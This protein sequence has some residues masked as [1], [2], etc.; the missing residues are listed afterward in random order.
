MRPWGFFWIRKW[1]NYSF[2]FK[3]FV[4]VKIKMI[5]SGRKLCS[6]LIFAV[7]EQMAECQLVS[8][9]GWKNE[10]HSVIFLIHSSFSKLIRKFY[11]PACA[12]Y[13]NL[14]KS[15]S[16]SSEIILSFFPF[17]LGA[18]ILAC[19]YLHLCQISVATVSYLTGQ[20]TLYAVI[21]F[22]WRAR[23]LSGFSCVLSWGFLVLRVSAYPC[24]A[25]M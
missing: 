9:L 2:P 6:M 14:R 20:M 19:K 12:L 17:S 13:F 10:I 3:T 8:L 18:R 23:D 1:F 25:G 21:C 22:L 7:N 11:Q 4:L 16:L 5:V 15:V 24:A